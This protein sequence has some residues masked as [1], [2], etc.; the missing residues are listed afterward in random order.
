MIRTE[1]PQPSFYQLEYSTRKTDCPRSYKEGVRVSKF[2]ESAPYNRTQMVVLDSERKVIFSR[3]YQWV[4]APGSMLSEQIR[5]D[6]D[7]EEIFSQVIGPDDPA[8][9]PFELTGAI[10]TFACERTDSRCRAVLNAEIT[11]SRTGIDQKQIFHET[12]NLESESFE[13]GDSAQ[14][15]EAMSRISGKFSESLREDLCAAVQKH[16]DQ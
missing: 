14:F 9:V 1:A 12:Y 3:N 5:L 4:A 16:A 15:A 7:R 11:L 2:A 6:L 10:H 8:D 13:Q